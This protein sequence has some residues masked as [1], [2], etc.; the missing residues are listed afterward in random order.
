MGVV[1]V[2]SMTL[3]RTEKRQACEHQVSPY[4]SASPPPSQTSHPRMITVSV[5]DSS[6]R[7]DL[8]FQLASLPR[9]IRIPLKSPNIEAA[10]SFIFDRRTS[11]STDDIAEGRNMSKGRQ[12]RGCR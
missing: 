12:F 7:Y 6:Q 9:Y 1:P 11:F 3:T 2:K 8:M 4:V 5:S 10:F